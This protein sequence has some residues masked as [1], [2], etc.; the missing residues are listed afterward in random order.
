M[1]VLKE[2]AAW[3]VVVVL[4][5][6]GV[7]VAVRDAARDRAR[8]RSVVA[9][10]AISYGPAGSYRPRSALWLGLLFA[11]IGANIAVALLLVG[12]F[13]QR[14]RVVA[15]TGIAVAA[16]IALLVAARFLLDYARTEVVQGRVLERKIIRGGE[17]G[18]VKNY[19]IAV[20]DG[21]RRI[22]G[23]PVGPRDYTRVVA[24]ARVRMHL[25]PRGRQLK[26]LEIIDLPQPATAFPGDL[27]HL[28]R[29]GTDDLLISPAMAVRA[30]GSPV[31]LIAVT[32]DAPR[33]R[34]YAY[35]PLGTSQVGGAGSA[36]ALHI[37]EAS[38]PDAANELARRLTQGNRRTWRHGNRGIFRS[39]L[40]YL[41]TW[42]DGALLIRAQV[43]DMDQAG[44]VSRMV[45]T[46][47]P[48]KPGR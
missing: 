3:A 22:A 32:P 10:K 31:E 44:D 43:A 28:F 35:V 33:T 15:G 6:A 23:I 11:W 38:D 36:P 34:S 41:M 45:H 27:A 2:V 14:W 19:W 5:G 16:A 18:E 40:A 46:L 37:T 1:E 7:G 26:R 8:R 39:G 24:G 25:T 20:D 29:R 4:A 13:P 12:A 47:K 9:G 30:L 48:P 21:R 42:G 17:N